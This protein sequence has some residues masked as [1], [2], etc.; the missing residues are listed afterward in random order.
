[1]IAAEFEQ[2]RRWLTGL[3]YRMLGSLASA[4]DM[5]QDAYL[6]LAQSTPAQAGELR[7]PRAY[8][9]SIVTRLCL[10][11]L[12]SSRHQRE[13]Y[14]GPW[15]PEP[16][17]TGGPGGDVGTGAGAAGGGFP[18]VEPLD[19]E[20][21]SMAFLVLLESLSP[22]ERAVYLL[23]EVF[24][25]SH[26]EVAEIL[27]RE[28]AACRQLLHRAKAHVEARRPRFRASREEHQRLLGAFMQACVTGD[29]PGLQQLLADDVVSL[30]D[31]GGRVVA[32]I[33]PL[34]GPDVVSRLLFGLMRKSAGHDVQ[35]Q[36]VEVN[37]LP[38]LRITTEHGL[39]S[40][41]T[42]AVSD[43]GRITGIYIVRNP[44]KLTRVS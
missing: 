1:V 34:T 5:V 37:G 10:D 4:E 15:L 38:G 9:A 24:D 12:K 26:T 7:S 19:A 33:R 22:L 11:E 25:C 31:G 30:S 2:H 18:P 32:A 17:L 23:A 13:T 21:L 3:A 16:L 8:L 41:T 36:L 28:P 40:L 43:D 27:G 14:V 6:R 35:F 44:D 42:V 39:H 29:L 20:S